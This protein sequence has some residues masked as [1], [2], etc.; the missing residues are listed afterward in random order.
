MKKSITLIALGA[1]TAMA[2]VMV[3]AA[4]VTGSEKLWSGDVSLTLTTNNG[5]TKSQNLGL[6]SR[7][8][9]DGEVWRNTFKLNALN[10]ESDGNRTAEKYFGSAKADRKLSD[11]DYLFLLLEHEDDEFG[12]YDYQTSFTLGYG[13]KVIN[14]DEHKLEFEV[15]PGYRHNELLVE[16]ADGDKEETETM[17]RGALNYD[18]VVNDST[19]FRQELSVEAGEEITV[20]KSLSKV[21]T[22]LHNQ[23]SLSVSYEMKHTSEVPEGAHEFDGTMVVALDYSF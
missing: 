13:R 22:K 2:P 17:L 14:T 6:K 21:K 20:S 18:W 7:A 1:A 23:F 19:S 15:G 16:N 5:N 8:V 9:R 10:E 3:Q 4:D 12:A 11:V